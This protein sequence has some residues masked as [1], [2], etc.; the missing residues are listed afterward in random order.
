MDELLLKAYEPRSTIVVDSHVVER[1]KFPAIDAHNH[2][3]FVT[4][5]FGYTTAGE[6]PEPDPLGVGVRASPASLVEVM[7]HAGISAMA[8]LTGRWGDTLKR[9][10]DKYERQHPGRFFTFANADWERSAERGFGEWAARQLEESVRAGARGFKVF[11]GLGLKARGPDGTLIMPDDERLDP[12][13]AKAGEL[14]VPVLIHVADPAAFFQPPDQYNDS[15][16]ELSHHPDWHFYGPGIPSF[17]ELVEAGIRMMSRHPKTT[18]ITAHTGW[19][20]ENLRFVAERMLDQLPNMYTDFSARTRWLG[21]QPHSSRKFFLKYQDRILF[22]T[23]ATPSVEMY[24]TYFRFLETDDDNF[25]ATPGRAGVIYIA[26]LR[27]PD[28]AL[29]KIYHLNTEKVI[30]GLGPF[31]GG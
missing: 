5:A 9:L 20:S 24:Q 1:P 26:G 21:R 7:D 10:I 15:Y 12:L 4:D 25:A 22:G 19:Y 23:D 2:L 17:L 14:R 16:L 11:K 8:N 31:G 27:L 13:W 30:P 29:E 6:S 18:F 3:G 28:E